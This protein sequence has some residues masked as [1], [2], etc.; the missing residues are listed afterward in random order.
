M[1]VYIIEDKTRK[2]MQMK[3]FDDYDYKIRVL[4]RCPMCNG[5][6]RYVID[7]SIPTTGE[8]DETA[9]VDVRC[10]CCNEAGDI[11]VGVRLDDLEGSL[12]C[13]EADEEKI[14]AWLNTFLTPDGY[15]EDAGITWA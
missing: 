13:N 2:V 6:G 7:L 5:S 14:I 1:S 12:I 4:A 8:R 9:S 15:S 10:P 3:K 11:E